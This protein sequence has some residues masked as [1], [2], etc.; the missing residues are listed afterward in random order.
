MPK[1]KRQYSRPSAGGIVRNDHH[2][3]NR[4]ENKSM[5]RRS[6]GRV[7]PVNHL[8]DSSMLQVPDLAKR[9]LTEQALAWWRR[10]YDPVRDSRQRK[11]SVEQK[12]FMYIRH[13]QSNLDRATARLYGA[14]R[15][16]AIRQFC[17]ARGG[18]PRVAC[19]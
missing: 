14:A 5:F 9:V 12:C 18:A 19:G 15:L 16:L 17:D 7:L 8:A 1:G 13:Q 11:T 4:K 3:R 10:R 6:S 2:R